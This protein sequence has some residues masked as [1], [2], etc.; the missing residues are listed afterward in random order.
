[1]WLLTYV[2]ALFNG[3]T[4]LILGEVIQTHYVS[5]NFQALLSTHTHTQCFCLLCVRSSIIFRGLDEW[6]TYNKAVLYYVSLMRSAA[7]PYHYARTNNHLLD[8]FTLLL[9]V[10]II[11]LLF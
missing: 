10:Y 1:M 8:M 3:L 2:G 9:N 4:L 11:R 6:N 5:T 7:C